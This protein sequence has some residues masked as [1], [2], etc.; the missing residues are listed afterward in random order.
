MALKQSPRLLMLRTPLGDD[1]LVLNAQHLADGQHATAAVREAAHL[2]DQIERRG[3]VLSI[4]ALV[5]HTAIE[6]SSVVAELAPLLAAAV[7]TAGSEKVTTAAD[8]RGS[9][10]HVCRHDTLLLMPGGA[11]SDARLS[12][13]VDGLIDRISAL[14][15]DTLSRGD[16]FT[17]T[18]SEPA[19][20][21]ALL[22]LPPAEAD[23]APTGRAHLGNHAP[24]RVEDGVRRRRVHVRDDVARSQHL[25]DRGQR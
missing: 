19:S 3:D 21:D 6:S 7:T 22:S 13:A 20:I 17:E 4:G 16:G 25:K 24:A 12:A 10:T 14:E 1:A 8:S 18:G 9:N 5:T 23:A 15:L 11:R 2:D